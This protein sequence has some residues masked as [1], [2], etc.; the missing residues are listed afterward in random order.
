MPSRP[1]ALRWNSWN[2]LLLVPLLV[3]VTPLYNSDEPH[4]FGFPLFYWLQFLFIPLGVICV[5]VV[6]RK[7]RDR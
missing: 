1:P 3:L 4:L 6:Y 5:A 7:T 2:L